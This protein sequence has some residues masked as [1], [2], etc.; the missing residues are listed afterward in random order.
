MQR[1]GLGFDVHAFAPEGQDRP[2]VL[3]GVRFPGAR[4]L[5]GHS[6]AD[7]VVH[8]LCDALLGAM[9]AGDMGSHFPDTDARYEGVSSLDF[10]AHV[11]SMMAAGGWRLVN[12]DLCVM[13]E[14]PKIAPRAAEMRAAMARPLGAGDDAI[15]VKATRPEGLGSLGRR[16]GIACQAIVLISRQDPEAP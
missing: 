4:G 16:E 12:A 13:A 9:G 2:L 3:G 15:N 11:A 1:V 7:V 8:A 6:D 5:A 10:L 14:A